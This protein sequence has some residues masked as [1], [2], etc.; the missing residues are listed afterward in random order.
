MSTKT[1][2][3]QHGL[4]Y[5][6]HSFNQKE[7]WILFVKYAVHLYSSYDFLL[8]SLIAAGRS[9]LRCCAA[10]N[11]RGPLPVSIAYDHCMAASVPLD[12]PFYAKF[13]GGCLDYIRSQPVFGDQCD[14]LAA[15]EI[16]S[17]V[18]QHLD[19]STIYGSTVAAVTAVRAY[20]AGLLLNSPNRLFPRHAN[21][22]GDFC[23]F[24]G[25]VC[26]A[27]YPTLSLWHSIFI[28]LHNQI[29]ERLAVINRHWADERLFQES[30]RLTT[31]VYH[32]IV[33]N[34]WLP[35]YIGHKAAQRRH[36]SGKSRSHY[37]PQANGASMQEFS[38]G[39]F[40]VFHANTPDD[41]NM[42]DR[43]YLLL[44]HLPLNESIHG[45]NVL[46]REFLTVMRGFFHDP[47]TLGAYPENVSVSETMHIIVPN[48]A[49]SGDY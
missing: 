33:F 20:R 43:E 8:L 36:V 38:S 37:D 48:D 46:E 13:G 11:S 29:A 32:N 15:A 5:C 18:T 42:Y 26:G 47:I 27:F 24:T 34:E 49:T 22:T 40:R 2:S 28:R 44:R 25:D 12:D 16:A 10:D 17:S 7:L 23:Y 14:R 19:H 45:P 31:A 1:V 21:C 9:G 30:R 41:I 35:P 6:K 4:P 3:V 39:V